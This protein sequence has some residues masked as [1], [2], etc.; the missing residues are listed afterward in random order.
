MPIAF[1]LGILF[2]LICT[3]GHRAPELRQSYWVAA[4]DSTSTTWLEPP[5]ACRHP[6]WA[7]CWN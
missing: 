7:S 1:V 6:T 3:T 2:L 5:S 4:R